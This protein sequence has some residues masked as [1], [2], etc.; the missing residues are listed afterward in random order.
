MAA[1]LAATTIGEFLN[2][3]KIPLLWWTIEINETCAFALAAV[4][5]ALLLVQVFAL[6]PFFFIWLERK[7]A[8]R[9]QDR[10]GPTRVGGR[11][12]WLQSLADG[13][14]LIQKE[15][16][17]PAAA[18]SMLF[19]MAP[20]IACVAS[21]GGFMVL[22]Q[23]AARR[24]VASSPRRPT[25]WTPSGRPFAPVMPGTLTAGTP[26]VV[27][28]SVKR[29]LP[30]LSRPSGASPGVGAVIAASKSAMISANAI[31]MV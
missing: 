21:F 17:V 22:P 27:Q 31:R 1:L 28:A 6:A 8:G 12:G 15:D 14:K 19:R 10:L 11:F 23:A 24:T 30:V 29:R 18:D 2:G 5:H 25:T 7:V 9:I 26:S 20:Y 13:V 16:L 4:V 3:V